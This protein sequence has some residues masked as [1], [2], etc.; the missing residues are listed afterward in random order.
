MM[1]ALKSGEEVYGQLFMKLRGTSLH[2]YHDPV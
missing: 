2:Q 1:D